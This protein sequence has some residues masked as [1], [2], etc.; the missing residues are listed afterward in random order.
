MKQ[1]HAA[2]VAQHL[3]RHQA[4]FSEMARHL[5]LIAEMAGLIC[6]RLAAGR[7]VL[8]CGNGGS[9]ADSQHFAAE[10]V[11]RFAIERRALAAIALSTDTS[12]LTSV[13][14]DYGFEHVFARQI[15]ALGQAGDVLVAISTSGNSPNVA[16]AAR[17]ARSRGM[18][19]IGFTGAKRGLLP[20]ISDLCL[21]APA[22]ETARIQEAHIFAIHCICAIVDQTFA[23]GAGVG[24]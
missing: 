13:G 8:V 12:A 24:A 15:E 23:A 1:A 17:T 20:Q 6:D 19:V 5:P 9:A 18:A 7:K 10:L 11:G 21:E 22:Q 2:L 16:A 3:E 4:A 14:N